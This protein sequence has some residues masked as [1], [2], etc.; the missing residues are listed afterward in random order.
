MKRLWMLLLFLLPALVGAQTFPD[1]NV[2]YLTGTADPTGSCIVGT[3]YYRTD[4][5]TRFTC[6]DGTWVQSATG[7]G[8]N[9]GAFTSPLLAGFDCTPPMYSFTDATGAGMCLP[10]ASKVQLQT[11][12]NSDGVTIFSIGNSAAW[13][14]QALLSG[15]SGIY[16]K[17]NAAVSTDI[18]VTLGSFDDTNSDF[19]SLVFNSTTPNAILTASDG[20]DTSTT[21]FAD[22]GTTFS[23]PIV[24]PSTV[25]ETEAGYGFTGA[26]DAS[27]GMSFDANFLYLQYGLD[28]D[29]TY[30]KMGVET[31]RLVAE[32]LGGGHKGQL[33]LSNA[34]GTPDTG[35]FSLTATEDTQ[36]ASSDFSC[37]FDSSSGS[38]VETGCKL[39]VDSADYGDGSSTIIFG[40]A[41]TT[42]SDPILAPNGSITAPSYSFTGSTDT[43]CFF[44]TG[45]TPGGITCQ[46]STQADGNFAVMSV[47]DDTG[48][49]YWY[50][51]A[52]EVG[53]TGYSTLSGWA[54]G[55]PSIVIDVGDASSTGSSQLNFAV[56]AS[57][58]TGRATFTVNGSGAS[59]TTILDP[60]YT[61][62]TD[63][64]LA[65]NGTA[66]APGFAFSE[67]TD[68]GI[69]RNADTMNIQNAETAVQGQ[70]VLTL[71]TTF[72]DLITYQS[73]D[74]T[75]YGDFQCYD[76][77]GDTECFI[78]VTDGTNDSFTSF[79]NDGTNFSDPVILPAG[80]QTARALQS[81]NE[82][83]AGIHFPAADQATF[84]ARAA[85]GSYTGEF[86]A[87]ASGS[88]ASARVYAEDGGQSAYFEQL[89]DSAV[90]SGANEVR[91]DDG[92]AGGPIIAFTDDTNTGIYSPA[93]E[94]VAITTAGAERF[95]V[96]DTEITSTLEIIGPAQIR[97]FAQAGTSTLTDAT[98]TTTIL[99][100]ITDQ[101]FINGTVTYDTVCVDATEQIRVRETLDFVCFNDA[102]T[103]TCNFQTGAPASLATG[104]AT[105]TP[106]YD[107]AAGTNT[108]TFRVDADCSLT[109]TTLEAYWEIQFSAPDWVT[110]TEQN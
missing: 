34:Q 18:A 2:V 71:G 110:V 105:M 81:P 29:A 86:R 20:T 60:T 100:S 80:T 1:G 46:S 106:T 83:R 22:D 52:D 69:R 99:F 57:G 24:A 36:F 82:A 104:G 51:H 45:I 44:D 21:T 89:S 10:G 50:L 65:S 37:S 85:T 11:S 30:I 79:L 54:S 56:L 61:S 17:F 66:A 32:T 15:D 103:E 42:F 102:D 93:D 48:L 64:I 13:N 62:F 67:N 33:L 90:F 39:T 43:G 76:N 9:G 16:G 14:L 41:A 53:T 58:V 97:A 25:R 94:E 98:P 78:E 12:M 70:A 92:S 68:M 19:A 95:T 77:A 84:G 23:D 72:L 4:N 3:E 74:A 91:F 26:P 38:G 8:F 47:A 40:P 35:Y 31:M 49:D 28:T 107:I 96:T 73:G 6:A 27:V 5:A 88:V 87:S 101:T 63:P 108:I 7:T 59:S 75:D 55:D 109:P